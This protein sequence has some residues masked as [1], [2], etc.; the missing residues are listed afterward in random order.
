MTNG[1]SSAHASCE[2]KLELTV[3]LGDGDNSGFQRQVPR[4]E[5]FV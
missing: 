2:Y 4:D 1:S 3:Y 5:R